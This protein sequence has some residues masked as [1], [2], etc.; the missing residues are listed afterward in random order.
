VGYNSGNARSHASCRT[1]IHALV[2][3]SYD[4]GQWGFCGGSLELGET[5]VDCAIRETREETGLDLRCE[6]VPV[7]QPFSDTLRFP[8]PFGAADSISHDSGGGR[9]SQLGGCAIPDAVVRAQL[10]RWLSTGPTAMRPP[11]PSTRLLTGAYV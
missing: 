10:L 3:A 4:A 6:P 11:S 9:G 8:T 5:L 2:P 1:Y 7:G